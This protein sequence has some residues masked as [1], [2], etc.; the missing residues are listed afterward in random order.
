V[1]S[2][3]LAA[4]LQDFFRDKAAL[5]ERHAAGAQWVS[6]YDFNNT[7]QYVINRDE[8]QISWLR[9]AIEELGAQVPDSW[10]ALP[11]QAATGR[12]GQNAVIRDDVEQ[13]RRFRERWAP[14]VRTVTHARHRKMFEVILGE[15]VEQERF[16]EDMLKG[17]VD[18]L[19]RRHATEG[20]GG[21]VLPTRWVE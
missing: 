17:R 16:F 19:G 20:T 7:Y 1:T 10:T 14:R 9:T 21:G 5:R 13:M 3:E 12:D 8:V 2:A 18:L 4:L 15:A 6:H 11:V